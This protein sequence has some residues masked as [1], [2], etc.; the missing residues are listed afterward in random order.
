LK[1]HAF[2][3]LL[4]LPLLFVQLILPILLLLQL[5]FQLLLLPEG[6]LGT[7]AL[8][9]SSALQSSARIRLFGANRSGKHGEAE[10]EAG[11]FDHNFAPICHNH[12]VCSSR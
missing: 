4:N 3:L 8:I 5:L 11:C 10:Q 2:E 6:L 9:Q 12:R 7:A 1:S